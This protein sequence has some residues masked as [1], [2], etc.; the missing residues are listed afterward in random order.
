MIGMFTIHRG[1]YSTLL[2]GAHERVLRQFHGLPFRIMSR[3]AAFTNALLLTRLLLVVL[4]TEGER[5][6]VSI[7]VGLVCSYLLPLSDRVVLRSPIYIYI[8]RPASQLFYL[9]SIYLL[10]NHHSNKFAT[11]HNYTMADEEAVDP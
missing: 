9:T 10:H 3:R 2:A 5:S 1:H 11:I 7:A 4:L 6:L 8:P